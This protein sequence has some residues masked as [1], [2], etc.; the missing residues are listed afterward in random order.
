MTTAIMILLVLVAICVLSLLIMSVI[1]YGTKASKV[2]VCRYCEAIIKIEGPQNALVADV[3]E[4]SVC[5]EC[6][7]K[8]N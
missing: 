6:I 7:Q 1:I 3:I 2:V 8:N 5:D 4:T